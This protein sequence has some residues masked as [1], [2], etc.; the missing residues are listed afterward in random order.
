MAH[1]CALVVDGV[2]A[3]RRRAVTLLRL[4]GFRVYE[5][6][7]VAEAFDKAARLR[8]TVVVV[9]PDLPDGDGIELLRE[10]RRHGS[11]A[12]F[13][14]VADSPTKTL[15][16]L[17]VQAGASAC[18]SKPLEPGDLVAFLR[19]RTT[20]PAAQGG[21]LHG[22]GQ[23]TVDWVLQQHALRVDSVR[24]DRRAPRGPLRAAQLRDTYAVPL[25][26]RS[27]PLGGDHIRRTGDHDRQV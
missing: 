7:G 4:A 6:S 18:L 9:D 19:G 15:R 13:L 14:A 20:G 1:R 16:N 26:R 12:Q 25:P 8:P 3:A 11:W 2:P 24:A 21:P 22:Q 5:A 23:P 10:L 17:A 27:S